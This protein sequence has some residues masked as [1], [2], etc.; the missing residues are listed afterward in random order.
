[1]NSF[2][3]LTAGAAAALTVLLAGCASTD[4]K[5]A[6]EPKP[7]REFR[8]GSNIPVKDPAQPT[9]QEERDRTAEQI[10]ALQRTG[11]GGKSGG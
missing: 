5:S 6:P 7:T 11:G 4:D 8:T 2:S 3:A 1:M 9:T 10:R